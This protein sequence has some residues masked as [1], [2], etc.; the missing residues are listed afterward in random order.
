MTECF[1]SGLLDE[2]KL[3]LAVPGELKQILLLTDSAD[4]ELL[5]YDVSSLSELN[6][7]NILA[8]LAVPG[9]TLFR[10]LMLPPLSFK[11]GLYC[12]LSGTGASYVVILSRG[13]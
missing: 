13:T 9:T 5:C 12:K 2:S 6:D 11:D 10:H 7:Q 3:V 8:V 4:A 1:S